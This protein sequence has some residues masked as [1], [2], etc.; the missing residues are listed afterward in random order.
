MGILAFCLYVWGRHLNDVQH[1]P[2]MLA[3]HNKEKSTKLKS[4][5]GNPN[6]IQ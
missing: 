2:N 4:E 1:I 3:G 5:S 6:G